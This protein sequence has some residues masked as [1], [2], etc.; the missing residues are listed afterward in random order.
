MLCHYV[1]WHYAEQ[2]NA[3]WHDAQCHYA[4][5]R[6]AIKEIFEKSVSRPLK[7]MVAMVHIKTDTQKRD[8]LVCFK[9]FRQK[10]WQNVNL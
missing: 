7:L 1:E 2:H 8:K 4:E 10:Y 6:G 5:C 9:G 3:K